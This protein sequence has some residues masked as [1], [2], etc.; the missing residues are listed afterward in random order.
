M[1]STSIF[2]KK[3]NILSHYTLSGIG[4]NLGPS[5]VSRE[6]VQDCELQVPNKLQIYDPNFCKQRNLHTMGKQLHL[7]GAPNGKRVTSGTIKKLYPNL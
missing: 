4:W 7:E 5:Y 6:F 3:N 2:P 1:T